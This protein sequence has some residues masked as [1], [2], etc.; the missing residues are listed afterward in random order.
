MDADVNALLKDKRLWVGAAV[1]AGVG[2]VMFL[3][4]GGSA[5]ATSGPG[6]A[7]G[8]TTQGTADTTG[9]D[10]ASYLGQYSQSQMELLNQWAA[11]LQTSLDA[12][13]GTAPAGS[14]GGSAIPLGVRNLP[15][16]LRYSTDPPAVPS[17][18]RFVYRA[19]VAVT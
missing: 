19:P 5:P 17:P 6:S 13:R 4:R 8:S 9:T 11:N 16:Y 7:T 3:K 15:Q 10:I 2:I 14:V 18:L 12:I 1:A